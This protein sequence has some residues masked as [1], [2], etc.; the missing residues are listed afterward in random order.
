MTAWISKI[1]ILNSMSKYKD[2]ERTKFQKAIQ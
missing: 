2:V 1:D